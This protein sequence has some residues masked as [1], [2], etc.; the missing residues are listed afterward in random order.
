MYPPFQCRRGEAP[1]EDDDNNDNNNNNTDDDDDD[2]DGNDSNN[3]NTVGRALTLI[4]CGGGWRQESPNPPPLRAVIP[5]CLR[6]LCCLCH[7][8]PKMPLP[9][10]AERD[11]QEIVHVL[12]SFRV[13]TVVV[14]R[15]NATAIVV[16]P[17]LLP[18]KQRAGIN[19]R[20]QCRCYRRT[21]P[22]RRGALC[23]RGNR[24]EEDL[25][26]QAEEG[27]VQAASGVG[28]IAS[29]ILPLLLCPRHRRRRPG[30][31]VNLCCY[32]GRRFRPAQW[33]ERR[34]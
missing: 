28:A 30:T 27:I 9:K 20:H 26:H 33:R 1:S 22:C 2:D 17:L 29:V 16:L 4:D 23:P 31:I 7:P 24:V 11:L 8:P 6:R 18:N 10:L 3:D 13:G 12:P 19:H 34:C 5:T 32:R 21:P 15:C 25:V 14:L